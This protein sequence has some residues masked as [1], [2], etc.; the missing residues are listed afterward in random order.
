MRYPIPGLILLLLFLIFILPGCSSKEQEMLGYGYHLFWSKHNI[1][2]GLLARALC[3]ETQ[4]TF[5]TG[6]HTAA[7]LAI[8]S[9]GPEKFTSRLRGIVQNTDIAGVMKDAVKDNIN[10]ILIIGDGMGVMHMAFP[11]YVNIARNTKEKT[12]FEKILNNGETGLCLTNMAG[13]VVAGS[14]AAA[15]AFACG[16]KTHHVLVGLDKDGFPLISVLEVAEQTGKH[17]GLLT[18]TKIT[19]ATPASF[20]AKISNRSKERIIAEQLVDKC[21]VEVLM[22]GGACYFIPESTQ[23]GRHGRLKN[24]K[25]GSDLMSRRQDKRDLVHEMAQKGY[26][27]AVTEDELKAID[28]R[29]EK[30][31][32]LFAGDGMSATIDRDDENTG[33]P[34]LGDMTEIALKTLSRSGRGFFIM[35]ECGRIDWESHRNDVG[36]VYKAMYEMNDVLEVCYR[37]YLKNAGKTLLVFT[38]DHETGGFGLAYSYNRPPGPDTLKSGDIRISKANF[39]SFDLLLKF[40]QQKKSLRKMIVDSDS[41]ESLQKTVLEN[42]AFSISP[43]QAKTVMTA[44]RKY[45]EP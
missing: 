16:E 12:A 10:V 43:G 30:I 23:V 18:D 38:A 44:K 3:P 31:F 14:A 17:T 1:P 5:G 25:V 42:T 37:H 29:T 40:T 24:M 13:H 4:A 7:P 35:V 6:S 8:G 26:A 22:G 34:A 21:D 11:I 39:L 45:L 20:Y 33:E 36:A 19:H 28:K 9:I 32:G 2:T 27:V 41:P 15:T